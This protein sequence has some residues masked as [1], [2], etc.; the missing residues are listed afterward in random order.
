VTAQIGPI[1]LN[2]LL[3]E[4]PGEW[5]L[6]DDI[7]VTGIT[8][9]SR[10]V[11]PGFCFVALSGSNW[12]GNKFIPDA[13]Q[14]GASLIVGSEPLSLTIPYLQVLD[15]R[16]SLAHLS[17]AFYRYPARNLVMIG[18]T[19]TDGKTTT[20]NLIHSILTQTGYAAGVISTVNA[21]IGEEQ[22]DTGFHVTTP[23]APD[24]QRFLRMM[25]DRKLKYAIIETTSHSLSQKRVI[26]SDFDIGVCTNITHEHLDYHQTFEAYRNAKAGLFEDLS[27]NRMK[28]THSPV[29]AVINM[30]DESFGFLRDRL[31]VPLISYGFGSEANYCAASFRETSQ[32]SR[33]ELSTSFGLSNR[34]VDTHQYGKYN[35]YNCLAALAVTTGLLE[36]PVDH[37]LAIIQE[38]IFIPGRMEQ[39]NLGQEFDAFVDFA[40][41]PNALLQTLLTARDIVE[42][43]QKLGKVIAIFGSAG[44]RDRQK[45]R[46]M[47][48][49][50]AEYA[51]FTILT[52]EDPRIEDLTSIL[53][54]M[55]A[56][57][58]AKGR[59]EGVDYLRIHDRGEAIQFGVDMAEKG[60]IVLVCGKG[61]EQ[62]MCFGTTEYPWDDRVAVRIAITN[63]LSVSSEEMPYLPTRKRLP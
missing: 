44:L 61:H 43:R 56:G 8:S 26:A 52:A 6:P 32:G 18:V 58:E 51:D 23:E 15:P 38:P 22:I 31:C 46:L 28:S 20:C 24:V 33:W 2:E 19:G 39:I 45:R 9:D 53:E 27:K 48:E 1:K 55:A 14:K 3:G 62:S 30:D 13:I 63:K 60:D 21:L 57:M 59:S 11:E 42:G 4:F 50:S 5:D 36:I 12:D 49:I 41:T 54:E 37:A 10:K 16:A 34:L 25:V 35:V 40:H 47:S 7:L 29:G 17:A